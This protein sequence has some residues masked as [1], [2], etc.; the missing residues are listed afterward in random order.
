MATSKLVASTW[1]FTPRPSNPSGYAPKPLACFLCRG[2]HRVNEC[3][4]KTAL[5]ALQA[6]IQSKEIEDQQEPE[7]EPGHMGALRFLGA[8]EKQP[9][10]PK[11]SQAKGLMFVDG[12][13]NGKGA[14]SVGVEVGEGCGPHE[15]CELKGF[16]HNGP[17]SRGITQVGSL[18]REDRPRSCSD[19]R[20]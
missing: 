17:I 14:K 20:L 9:R 5:S 1:V 19:G 3:P 15:S 16:T 7:E 12:S 2:P 18:A 13:I 8:V 4:H 11:K 6:H 10:S